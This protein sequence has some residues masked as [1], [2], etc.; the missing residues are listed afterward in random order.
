MAF[1]LGAHDDYS[2]QPMCYVT[3]TYSELFTPDASAEYVIIKLSTW[4]LYTILLPDHWPNHKL[5][6]T[7]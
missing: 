5:R 2:F 4:P 1:L 3:L 7:L 6:F